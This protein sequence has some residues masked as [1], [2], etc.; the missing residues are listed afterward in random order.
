MKLNKIFGL[1]AV[2]VLGIILTGAAVK[3]QIYT[4][5][6]LQKDYF[7]KPRLILD[8]YLRDF[9]LPDFFGKVCPVIITEVKVNS[10]DY[11]EDVGEYVEIHNFGNR[12]VDIGAWR[13]VNGNDVD[14]IEDYQNWRWDWGLP[15]TVIPPGGYALIVDIFRNE[16]SPLSRSEEALVDDL[17]RD[18]VLNGDPE[19]VLVVR[20]DDDAIGNGLANDQDQIV[21]ITDWPEWEGDGYQ[22]LRIGWNRADNLG[23]CESCSFQLCGWFCWQVTGTP[24]PGSSNLDCQ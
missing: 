1:S 2:I 12:P 18:I 14:R 13:I 9:P 8:P 5:T 21:I 23:D 20:V 4:P 15:G 24:S 6:K 16:G 19:K 22:R 7:E 10:P 3:A 17:L 11:R